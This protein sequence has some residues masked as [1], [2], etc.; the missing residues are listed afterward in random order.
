MGQFSNSVATNEAE[1]T[2]PW[3]EIGIQFLTNRKGYFSLSDVLPE[4]DGA[5]ACIGNYSF[6]FCHENRQVRSSLKATFHLTVS[7]RGQR[8]TGKI[9][10][11]NYHHGSSGSLSTGKTMSVFLIFTQGTHRNVKNR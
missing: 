6:E 1:V 5:V 7:I 11:N 9:Q 8:A 2:S 4:K 10:S 3:G